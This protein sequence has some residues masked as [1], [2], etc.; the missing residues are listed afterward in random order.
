[1]CFPRS[2]ESTVHV[3][4]DVPHFEIESNTPKSLELMNVFSQP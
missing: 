4:L 3:V 1:M 2:S